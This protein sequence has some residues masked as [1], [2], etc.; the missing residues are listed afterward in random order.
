LIRVAVWLLVARLI[1]VFWIVV[2]TFRNASNNSFLHTS[3]GFAIYWTDFAAFFGLGGVW[4]YF[5]LGQLR[6]RPLLP[7]H[8]PRVSLPMP[9]AV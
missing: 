3:N 1:D 5:F 8:D 7:L 9:E 4:V 2:P 6:K